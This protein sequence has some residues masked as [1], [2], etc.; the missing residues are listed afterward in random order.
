MLSTTLLCYLPHGIVWQGFVCLF[1]LLLFCFDLGFSIDLNQIYCCVPL[2]A[3]SNVQDMYVCEIQINQ[4]SCYIG[5][6]LTG[7]S[8]V[9]QSYQFF[10]LE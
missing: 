1:I 10:C 7:L 8:V 5:S 2:S 3:R 9:S 4:V 6:G